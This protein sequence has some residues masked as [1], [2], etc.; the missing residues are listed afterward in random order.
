MMGANMKPVSFAIA[1]AATAGLVAPLP[2]QT[3]HDHPDQI[4]FNFKWQPGQTFTQRIVSRTVGSCTLPP[5]LPEQ[6]M[7][8]TMEETLVARCVKVNDD[9]SGEFEMLIDGL[10]MKMTIGG[11]TINYDSRT[12]DPSA[13]VDW[14]T[15]FVSRI[16]NAMNGTKFSTTLTPSGW[17]VKI[18]GLGQALKKM[19]ASIGNSE[20][21]AMAKGMLDQMASVMDENAIGQEIQS[22]YRLVPGKPGPYRIGDR[23]EHTWEFKLP[24]LNLGMK[25]KGEYELA[26]LETINGHPC[27]KILTRETVDLSTPDSG[28]KTATAQTLK[29]GPLAQALKQLDLKLTTSGGEGYAYIDYRTGEIVQVRGTQT[30]K[31]AMTIKPDPEGKTDREQQGT[32]LTQTFSMSLRADLVEPETAGPATSPAEAAPGSVKP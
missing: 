5:P 28:D 19:A 12:Y 26:A 29:N 9:G 24:F 25:G 31:L 30:M 6:K 4:E 3:A 15:S 21:E 27:A 1:L 11:L 16:F 18:E 7:S 2:A 10:A 20:Q 22:L 8:Q 14:V 23:W 13:K 32:E 17:A